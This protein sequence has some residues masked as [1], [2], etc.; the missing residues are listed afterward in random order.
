M[1]ESGTKAFAPMPTRTGARPSQMTELT[2]EPSHHQNWNR[3]PVSTFW[4]RWGNYGNASTT[5]PL[6]STAGV[7]QSADLECPVLG[8]GVRCDGSA[9][10]ASPVRHSAR[11]QRVRTYLA[12]FAL[13]LVLPLL[14][15]AFFGL[16]RM[17]AIEQAQIERRVM[18]ISQ[19]LRFVLDRELDRALV[20]LETLATSSELRTGNLNAFHDQAVLALKP[21]KAAIVLID[22]PYR[23]L[24]VTL[25]DCS[26][27]IGFMQDVLGRH[28]SAS[29]SPAEVSSSP[30]F[31]V[32]GRRADR[33]PRAGYRLRSAWARLR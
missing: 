5:W 27:S 17:A 32:R 13:A 33:A 1:G 19:N 14:A 12:L 22:T 15:V 9:M 7:V 3:E 31:P 26:C 28:P 30:G 6:D 29:S 20:T 8:L 4:F 16:N 23:Q 11:P 25:K 2:T 10:D 24:V 21:A 18:Q